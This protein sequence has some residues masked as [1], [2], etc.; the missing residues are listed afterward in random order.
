M[1]TK[2]LFVLWGCIYA[3][4]VG[5]GTVENPAGFGKVLLVLTSLIFFIPPGY[6]LY[7]G[8]R[9][10]KKKQVKAVRIIAIVSLSLTLILLVAN[11]LSVS[12]SAEAGKLLYELLILVSA[13]MVCSQYWAVSLFL[14]AC[15]LWATFTKPKKQTDFQT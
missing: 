10:G 15:L 11:F 12:G 4:C 2:I 13:P 7:D 6:I 14:W 9:S 1:K 8:I 3:L 5:L